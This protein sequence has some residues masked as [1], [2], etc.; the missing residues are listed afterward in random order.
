MWLQEHIA[1]KHSKV[2]KG[3]TDAKP[4]DVFT[5]VFVASARNKYCEKLGQ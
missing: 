4:L 3:R 2:V 5:K 1:L